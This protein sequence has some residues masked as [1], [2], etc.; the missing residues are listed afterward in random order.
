MTSFFK[1]AQEAFGAGNY[2]RAIDLYEQAI[3]AN[4]ALAPVYGFSLDRARARL[5]PVDPTPNTQM[6]ALN[7][8]PVP[9]SVYLEDLYKEV[10]AATKDKPSL[11]PGA[12]L[13]LVSVIM[14][15]HNVAPYIEAA[16]MS[17][18]RQT[19]QNIELLVI[20]D[21]S[22][23]GTWP[24]LQRLARTTRG[25]RCRRL[26][27]NLGTYFAKNYGVTLA[28]GQFV[29]FQDGDDI[30]HP[31]R[32]RLCMAQFSSP[33]V[34]AVH[35][36]YSRVVFPQGRVLPINGQIKK[37]GL[38]TLG[39]RRSV[40]DE[41]GYFNCTTKASD[42]EFFCRLKIYC[43]AK[44]RKIKALDLPL[45]YNTLREGSLF[46]DMIANDP[47][48]DGAIEQIPSPS[49]LAY[50][51]A[52]TQLHQTLGLNKFRDFFRY[53]PIRDLIPVAPDM[54]R[55]EN[56][57]LPVVACLCSI[58]ERIELL[59]KTLASLAPQVDELNVYLDRYPE[60][61]EFVKTCHPRIKVFL[62][63][64]YPGLRDNGK[65]LPF[66]RLA[67]PCYYL[68][69]DDDI[70]YPPDYVQAMV[71]KVEFYGRKAVIGVHGVL[72]PGQ[73]EGYFSS[74]R[75]VF[76][77][78]NMLERDALVS[79]LGT[80]TVAFY[81]DCLRGLDYRAFVHPG[82]ADIFF[83]VFCK[84]NGIPMVATSRPDNWLVEQGAA[85]NTLYQEF[86]NADERQA[87][88]VRANMPWGYAAI[89][90]VVHAVGQ[91]ENGA[92]AGKHLAE[93]VPDLGAYLW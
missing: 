38:I 36:C 89:R 28:A 16:V 63:K 22:S 71:R 29:F 50:V 59:K 11:L 30:C 92:Q 67:G 79:N 43:K 60:V 17:V 20:D 25:L 91:S 65:F 35:C 5:L 12:Q 69:A 75:Q 57:A 19:Y 32:V 31:D 83:S 8:S 84:R 82:M 62:S 39:F 77:F 13:P 42:D 46:A 1:S 61:P 51:K 7:R 58:P 26:N 40:F 15:A 87:S 48:V 24:I 80:G 49:R 2:H 44:G 14:T 33:D 23:D 37:L 45:Y 72:I 27:A 70:V 41:I 6:P 88:L 56:P 85:A 74:F 64:D 68:T 52:F 90:Q 78:T 93:L 9:G 76:S 47:A 53:P 86:H 18:L 55:L 3:A 21:Q 73:P 54:T 10:A 81:S 4:P 66:T 34:S